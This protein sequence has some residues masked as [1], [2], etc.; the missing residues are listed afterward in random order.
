MTKSE[1]VG[2]LIRSRRLAHPSG[3]PCMSLDSRRLHSMKRRP[4]RDWRLTQTPYDLSHLYGSAATNSRNAD[5]RG[6]GVS[7]RTGF[8][9]WLQERACRGGCPQPQSNVTLHPLFAR[10]D[11]RPYTLRAIDMNDLALVW[12]ILRDLN[13][14]G[15]RGASRAL[16]TM[17]LSQGIFRG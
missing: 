17:A 13:Q 1:I 12:P 14:S 6:R 4:N 11:T 8:S 7:T 10:G 15:A 5:F 2:R 3:F 16:E 9:R